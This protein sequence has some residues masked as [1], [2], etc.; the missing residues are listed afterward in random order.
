M[1][2]RNIW[3]KSQRGVEF[4]SRYYFKYKKNESSWELKWEN[5]LL[6]DSMDE[7][8]PAT[9]PEFWGFTER[10]LLLAINKLEENISDSDSRIL[11]TS[12]SFLKGYFLLYSKESWIAVTK[13]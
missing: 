5:L 1:I 11:H 13:L 9:P 7:Y 12:S 10:F 4:R 6:I 2:K 3:K 8:I